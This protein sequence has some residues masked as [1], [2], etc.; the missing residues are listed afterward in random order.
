MSGSYWNVGTKSSVNQTD[1]EIRAEGGESFGE[2]QTF[3]VF[4]PPSV[5]LFDGAS[6]TL[7]F[8]VLIDYDTSGDALPTK[9]C[10]DSLTGA[11]SL[12]QKCTIY[13]GNRTTT[14][15]T[16]DHYNSWVSVKYSYDTND[17]IRSKRALTEGCGEWT[18][19][20]RG[21]LGTS[22]SIQNNVLYSP[23][24][25][26]AN[27][28]D[29]PTDTINTAQPFIKASVSLKIHAGLFA[30]NDKAVPNLVM[31]GC[32]I[33]FTC[34]ENRKVF[35]V[36]DSTTPHRRCALGPVFGSVAGDGAD[37]LANGTTIGS[38]HTLKANNQS[39][40]QHSPFQVGEE[41]VL[42]SLADGTEVNFDSPAIIATIES[43]TAD[44][45]IKYTFTDN[46]LDP[47]GAVAVGTDGAPGFVMMSK[48]DNSSAPTYTISN[49]RMVVRQL[50]VP[51]ETEKKMMTMMKNGG[52][53]MYDIP[54]VACVLESTAKTSLVSTLQIP[55]EHAKCRSVV[56]QP[57]DNEQVYTL[58]ENA[59]SSA[60]Y[61]YTSLE[62]N[63]SVGAG[64]T[65]GLSNYSDRSGLSGIGD[66]L[67]NYN[68][69]ID[70]EI[71]PSRR[72][73]TDKASS[74]DKGLNSDWAIETEKAIN[75]SHDCICRSMLGFKENFVIG[76]ALT[77]DPSTI[78]DGRGK[79]FR[80]V[81][82]YG[83]GQTKN[84]LWKIFISHIK[85]LQIKGDSIIVEQ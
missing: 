85:T 11:N 66:K 53:M 32:Y 33:E 26:Q 57:T 73:S 60:T 5:K 20:S 47:S 15:E 50:G 76:R 61:K 19:A 25:E 44:E 64:Q 35:R 81:I 18:P 56:C 4:I 22:K 29:N 82:R 41:I 6:S 23:Y 59:D 83:T 75:Q 38:F 16:L 28:R 79:D 39:D 43:G 21:T 54:S 80:L 48:R 62:T 67:D 42:R 2:N 14:L 37:G 13:A 84:K 17:S 27:R 69:V 9:W 55:I 58:K 40:P 68:F 24:M 45:P 71:V 12:F 49:I 77:L 30:G 1:I 65:E 7:N 8:D 72:V 52:V 36:L 74:L 3:G 63:Y 34:E 70:H 31:G 46:T 78:Y 10:L 51:A